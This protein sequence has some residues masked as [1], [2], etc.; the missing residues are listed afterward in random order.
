M[1]DGALPALLRRDRAVVLSGLAAVVVLAWAYLLFGAGIKMEMMDMGGGQMMAM[2]PEWTLGYGAL[3]FVMWVAMMVAMMLPSAAPAILLAAALDRRRSTASAPQQGMLFASG[4][5]LVWSAFSLLATLLQWGLDEA[6]LLSGTMAA[7]NRILAGA[8]L[9]AAGAY[10]W[11]PLKNTCLAHCRSPIA[12]LLQH[13]RQG[14]L[15][16][17]VTGMRHGLF[18]LGCCWILM[19][20]LFV[21]GLMNLL[22]VAAIAL[23]VLIEK[24][25]PWGGRMARITGVVLAIWGAAA[26]ALAI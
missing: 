1:T 9:V 23:L 16:A 6:G 26:L 20:L 5:L 25:A 22:W 14:R 8:V 10:E 7:G 4:Y 19:A 15:G 13:W 3:I 21:G 2:S 17:V 18:C 12:F 24:T 11:T